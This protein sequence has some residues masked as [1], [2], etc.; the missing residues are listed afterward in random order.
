[1]P[2]SMAHALKALGFTADIY[3]Y[4]HADVIYS[5]SECTGLIMADVIEY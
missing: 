5:G 4:L 2:S 3:S 1:M